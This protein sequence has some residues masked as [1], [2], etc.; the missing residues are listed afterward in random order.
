LSTGETLRTAGIVALAFL[1]P[2][3]SFAAENEVTVKVNP[4]G[5]YGPPVMF[6]EIKNWNSVVITLERSI[7]FGTCPIYTVEIHGDGAVVY[8]GGD[9]VF[10]KGERRSRAAAAGVAKLVW[11]FRAANFFSMRDHYAA[12]ITD[13]P[14]YRTSISFDH[15]RKAVIDYF[16]EMVGMP[17]ALTKLEDEIDR[18]AETDQWVN[19]SGRTCRGQPVGTK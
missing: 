7:C 13:G 3:A 15:N 8:R 4:Q 12:S 9:C 14:A 16:G 11:A 5:G 10:A 1:L 2:F 17:P 6:P 18:V 19:G